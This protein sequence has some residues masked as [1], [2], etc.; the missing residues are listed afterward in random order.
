MIKKSAL[1]IFCLAVLSACGGGLVSPLDSGDRIPADKAVLIGKV[2]LSPMLDEDGDLTDKKDDDY[3]TVYLSFGTGDGKKK[4]QGGIYLE[5]DEVE[6]NKFFAVPVDA[7]KGLTLEEMQFV[8]GRKKWYSRTEHVY[9]SILSQIQFQIDQKLEPGDVYSIGNIK[10]D[11]HKKSFKEIGDEKYDEEEAHYIIPQSIS[12]DS[13]SSGVKAW[14][15]KSFPKSDEAVR[16]A[17]VLIKA[18]ENA[19]AFRETQITTTYH[20]Y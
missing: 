13:D 6:T 16:D 8:I 20:R 11:L 12:L 14:F 2:S 10:I 18:T 19:N 17:K 9:R 4:E 5:F 1:C 3:Q 15:K 7:V